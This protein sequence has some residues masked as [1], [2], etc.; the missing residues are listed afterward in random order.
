MYIVISKI[1]HVYGCLGG[2]C[3][4]V[5]K[6]TAGAVKCI[7]KAVNRKHSKYNRHGTPGV[8]FRNTLRNAL[9]K[10]VEMRRPTP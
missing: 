1:Y 8:Q 7:L 2:F 4:L 5:S 3:T 9:A 10:I 6:R